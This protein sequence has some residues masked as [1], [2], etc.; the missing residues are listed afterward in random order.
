MCLGALCFTIGSPIAWEH[1]YG[2]LPVLFVVCFAALLRGPEKP[3][4]IWIALAVAWVLTAVRF[5]ATMALADTK[6]NFLQSYMYF[7]A[8]I[9]LVVLHVLRRPAGEKTSG[10]ADSRLEEA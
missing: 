7:G 9:L 5:A 3:R 1:H 4:A 10:S 6:L 2:I 8:L